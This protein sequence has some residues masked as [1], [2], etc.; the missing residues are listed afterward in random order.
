MGYVY[1]ITN[2]R[3]NK[4]YIGISIHEPEKRRIKDHLSGYGSRVIANAVKKYGKDAFTYE[5]LEANVFPELLPDLEVAYIANHNTIAPHGYNLN[6]GGDLAI[7]S[8]ETRHKLSELAKRRTHLPETRR[9]LSEYFRGENHPHFGKPRPE[10]TRRKISQAKRHPDYNLAYKYFLSL[11]SGMLMRE[12]RK[13]LFGKF[14]HVK[15]CTIYKW[16]RKWTNWKSPP[17]YA[18]A[19]KFFLSLPADMPLKAKRK[20]LYTE[21]PNVAEGT[22]RYLVRKWIK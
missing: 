4:S 3:N 1:K 22:I 13:C 21:F 11:P 6:S 17:E 2:T 5:V 9:K 14:S 8:E 20:L 18:S 16:V 15:K 7:P 10:E 19:H 12:K